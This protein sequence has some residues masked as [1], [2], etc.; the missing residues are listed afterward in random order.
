MH[1]IIDI[2]HPFQASRCLHLSA[3]IKSEPLPA[4][5]LQHA[6]QRAGSWGLVMFNSV[7]L[8]GNARLPVLGALIY[9]LHK[10]FDAASC[11]SVELP[12]RHCC[13]GAL[14]AVYCEVRRNGK[15]HV[16]STSEQT[17]LNWCIL[18]AV[19]TCTV[20]PQQPR[21]LQ[22]TRD[23][24][25]S[26]FCRSSFNR[27]RIQSEFAADAYAA[28]GPSCSARSVCLRTSQCSVHAYP[29]VVFVPFYRHARKPRR[30]RPGRPC[31][32][33]TL[34]PCCPPPCVAH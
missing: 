9:M 18:Q 25:T 7:G 6:K 10:E 5:G 28:P 30:P 3:N 34:C 17:L 11:R 15:L 20:L 14:L 12:N 16:Y 24:L 27:T 26:Q 22:A 8:G 29:A 21:T 13:S 19:L 33:P 31:P 23:G 2:R 4:Y 32:P 1:I